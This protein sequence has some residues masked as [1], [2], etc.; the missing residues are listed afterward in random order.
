MRS[1]GRGHHGPAD[2]EEVLI[3]SIL[4]CAEVYGKLPATFAREVAAGAGQA[5]LASE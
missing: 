3:G 1:A 2:G 4:R 5:G